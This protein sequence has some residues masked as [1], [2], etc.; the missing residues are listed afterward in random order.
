MRGFVIQNH[1]LELSLPIAHE[2]L[3]VRS[4]M[5]EIWKKFSKKCNCNICPVC[6]LEEVTVKR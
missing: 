1:L 6:K 5:I 2:V 4:G 3:E